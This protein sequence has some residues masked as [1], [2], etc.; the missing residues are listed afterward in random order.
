MRLSLAVLL[1]LSICSGGLQEQTEFR[2][3]PPQ[4]AAR[5]QIGELAAVWRYAAPR[6]PEAAPIAGFAVRSDGAEV[7][8]QAWRPIGRREQRE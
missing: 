5:W 4:S 3:P 1:V 6:G 7:R 8:R 2:P